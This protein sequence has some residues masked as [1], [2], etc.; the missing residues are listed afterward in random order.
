ME[1]GQMVIIPYLGERYFGIIVSINGNRI[2]VD[3]DCR[4]DYSELV[5]V[6]ASEVETT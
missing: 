4:T 3:V 6:D 2:T 1:I 5:T